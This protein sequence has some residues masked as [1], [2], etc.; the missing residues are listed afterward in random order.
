MAIQQGTIDLEKVAEDFKA[1]RSLYA[2]LESESHFIL[3][4]GLKDVGVKYHSL[5]SRVKQ[6][7]SFL[8]KVKTKQ[9]SSP[10]EE[11]HDLVGLRVV[12]LF[13][14]DIRRVG[15]LIH[16]CFSV[17]EEDNKIEGTDVSSFGY[18]SVHFV[19]TMKD[20]YVGPRYDPI[21]K[22][23]FEIQVRTIAMDAWANVS[24]Y[25]AYKSDK[26]VP[27]DLKRDFYALSGLFYVADK[28]FELFYGASKRS[29]ETMSQFFVAATPEAKAEQE[30]NLDSLT[31]YLE[32]KFPDRSHSEPK[33]VSLLVG[34]L[35][36][37]GYKTIGDVDRIVTET[38]DAFEAYEKERPPLLGKG[39]RFLD[40]GVVRISAQLAD[41]EF[42]RA[43]VS[44]LEPED[45]I[46][47]AVQQAIQRYAP[48]RKFL[49]KPK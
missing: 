35:K 32:T 18:L 28:H 3:E 9:L 27:S 48:Y 4:R 17:I 13:L 1:N 10:L 31:A 29:Q 7:N 6:L 34:E 5:T 24:H 20:E 21:S 30:L 46:E 41:D 8:E 43:I 44:P 45:Q 16:S 33:A 26:D 11:I 25:L 19:A 23:P 22:L 38:K 14:S 40:V 42:I 12:C 37:V 15:E 39:K 47:A 36:S 49:K 2:Q